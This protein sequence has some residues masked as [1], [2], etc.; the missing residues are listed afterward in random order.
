MYV[1]FCRGICGKFTAKHGCL[2]VLI[3]FN[4][5]GEM[6]EDTEQRNALAMHENALFNSI[7]QQEQLIE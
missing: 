2:L 1:I 6:Q 5:L 3:G 4:L 7:L